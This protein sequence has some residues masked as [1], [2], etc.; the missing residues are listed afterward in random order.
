MSICEKMEQAVDTGKNVHVVC[1]GGDEYTGEA[2]CF[3]KGDD[4]DDGYATF[5]VRDP[6]GAICL[7]ENEITS[8]EYVA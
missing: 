1:D 7:G 5:C 8:I 6:G 2:F 4:E 3:T